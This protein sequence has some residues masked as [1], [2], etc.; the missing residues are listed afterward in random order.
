VVEFVEDVGD[1]GLGGAPGDGEAA[2]D[3]LVGGVSARRTAI[4]SPRRVSAGG[5]ASAAVGCVRS[6]SMP[7]ASET[8]SSWVG[9]VPSSKAP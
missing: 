9:L 1:V 5:P 3:V 8:A 6:G 2:G 4:C 7:T